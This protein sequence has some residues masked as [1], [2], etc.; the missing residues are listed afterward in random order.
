MRHFSFVSV[1]A[2]NRNLHR[3]LSSFVWQFGELESEFDD[4]E[5]DDYD[6]DI[7]M[8]TS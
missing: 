2:V 6:Y 3:A 8:D 5:D 4:E 1:C 7:D